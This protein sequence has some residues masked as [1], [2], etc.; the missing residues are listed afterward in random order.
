MLWA[1]ATTSSPVFGGLGKDEGE[2][3]LFPVIRP[4]FSGSMGARPLSE[5]SKKT[6]EF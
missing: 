6:A 2:I 5:V 1:A 4:I 3:N